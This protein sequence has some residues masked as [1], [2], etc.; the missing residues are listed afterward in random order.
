[1]QIYLNLVPRLCFVSRFVK[2][3]LK[4]LHREINAT[5]PGGSHEETELAGGFR[6]G[7]GA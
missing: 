1:M 6:G 7:S 5:F 2:H 3:N 4:P